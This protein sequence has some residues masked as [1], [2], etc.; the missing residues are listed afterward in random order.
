MDVLGF[1]NEI[2]SF[3]DEAEPTREVYIL[4][5]GIYGDLCSIYKTKMRQVIDP[6]VI[7]KIINYIK[8]N[9]PEKNDLAIWTEGVTLFK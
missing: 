7:N 9:V 4:C 3:E 5:L 1:I 2:T 8:T 6:N